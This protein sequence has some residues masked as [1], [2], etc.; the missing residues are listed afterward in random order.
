MVR[1]RRGGKAGEAGGERRVGVGVGVGVGGLVTDDRRVGGDSDRVPGPAAAQRLGL[2]TDDAL[3]ARVAR[4]RGEPGIA[5][6]ALLLGQEG[7]PAFT[8][9][10]LE[11][12][13]FE[14]GR[15]VGL[16]ALTASSPPRE[17]RSSA[18][19]GESWSTTPGG[20]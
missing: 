13:F 4:H 9:S 11:E 17:S 8:R 6:L 16:P 18:S 20:P 15:S 3:R 10:D 7:G 12:R 1:I 2:I 14:V 19:P 5:T